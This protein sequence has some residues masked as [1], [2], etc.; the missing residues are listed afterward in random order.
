MKG[1]G[2]IILVFSNFIVSSMTFRY[3]QIKH[4]RMQLIY[5]NF[6]F[7]CGWLASYWSYFRKKW[8]LHPE[9][10]VKIDGWK[11]STVCF[12]SPVFQIKIDEDIS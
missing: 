5:E 10:Q 11:C 9:K 3:T 7:C 4:F 8:A 2:R 6:L 12:S 1:R